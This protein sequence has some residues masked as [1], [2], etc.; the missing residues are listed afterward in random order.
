MLHLENKIRNLV[1]VRKIAFNCILSCMFKCFIVSM[2][3]FQNSKTILEDK[4]YNGGMYWLRCGWE[5][6]L[7]FF[8]KWWTKIW[9]L[10][11]GYMWM[12]IKGVSTG[13][14]ENSDQVRMC[15][16]FLFEGEVL[17]LEE[18]HSASN[19]SFTLS[20]LFYLENRKP[21]YLD[22]WPIMSLWGLHV[23]FKS[24]VSMPGTLSHSNS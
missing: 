12:E 10:L 3:S 22:T 21:L 16:S 19:L 14:S 9:F 6:K 7:I 15:H 11:F 24:K 13:I 8:Q 18:R 2:Y 5:H 4:I 23:F 17:S 20:G 1:E